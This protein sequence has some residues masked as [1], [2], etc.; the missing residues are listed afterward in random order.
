MSNASEHAAADDAIPSWEDRLV[1]TSSA[2]M[3]MQMQNTHRAMQA[4]IN[5]LRAALSLGNM[6]R[7]GYVQLSNHKIANAVSELHQIAITYHAT[8]ELRERITT[9][10]VPLLTSES[11]S[12]KT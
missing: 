11:S 6:Q 12:E 3:M 5:D 7:R 10:V 2:G 9:F 8:N 4:E 1:G